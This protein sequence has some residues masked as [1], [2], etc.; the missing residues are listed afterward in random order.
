MEGQVFAP[1][2]PFIIRC[3]GTG[4][5]PQEQS[6]IL[7]HVKVFGYGSGIPFIDPGGISFLAISGQIGKSDRWDLRLNGSASPGCVI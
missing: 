6:D 7:A 1:V 2:S 3:T 4:V 5:S